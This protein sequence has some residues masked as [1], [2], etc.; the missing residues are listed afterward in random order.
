MGAMVTCSAVLD[1][2]RTSG[3]RA[4]GC[5]VWG[6]S[7][8]RRSLRGRELAEDDVREREDAVRI[9]NTSSSSSSSE[10]EFITDWRER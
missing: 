3:G 1:D 4:C 9:S 10:S 5:G 8:A 7:T 2:L 6:T